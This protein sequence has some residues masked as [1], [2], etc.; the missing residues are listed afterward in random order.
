M[1]RGIDLVKVNTATKYNVTLTSY[2]TKFN[3]KINVITFDLGPGTVVFI[4]GA[5]YGPS[6]FITSLDCSATRSRSARS[7]FACAAVVVVEEARERAPG[8]RRAIARPG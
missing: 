8:A 1:K 7:I 5:E 4:S 6:Q 2:S 3:H